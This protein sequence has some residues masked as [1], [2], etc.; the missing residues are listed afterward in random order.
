MALNIKVPNSAYSTQ[1]VSL[2]S[3]SFAV[4]FIYN[5]S[6][7][8]W[9]MTVNNTT[10]GEKATG[11]KVM[12]NQR[13]T[14]KDDYSTVVADGAIWCLRSLSDFSPVG[15]DNLGKDKTYQITWFSNAEMIGG[16]LDGTVQL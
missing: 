13:L 5:T 7:L 4:D 16:G 12:P 9:Y 1:N 2:G 3:E 15:R 8:S 6:D 10:T 11:I 14:D